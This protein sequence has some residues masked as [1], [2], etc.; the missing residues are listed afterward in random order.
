MWTVCKVLPVE[1]HS[2]GACASV[3]CYVELSYYLLFKF[4]DASFVVH[5][6]NIVDENQ[7]LTPV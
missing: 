1:S 3:M 7:N 4:T 6:Q 5:L 2:T